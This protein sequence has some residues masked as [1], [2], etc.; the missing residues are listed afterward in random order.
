MR[1][2]SANDLI[3]STAFFGAFRVFCGSNVIF[4]KEL[5]FQYRT[6]FVP[7]SVQYCERSA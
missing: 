3:S 6:V 5:Y 2:R 7:L 4:I 1:G